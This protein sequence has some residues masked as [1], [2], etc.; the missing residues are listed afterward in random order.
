MAQRFNAGIFD[1][2][3]TSPLGDERIGFC[4]QRPSASFVPAGLDFV[5]MIQIPAL[6]RWA[7]LIANQM[8]GRLAT[9]HWR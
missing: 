5:W 8:S 3:K 7:I 1:D 9:S 6:K 2:M 4:S